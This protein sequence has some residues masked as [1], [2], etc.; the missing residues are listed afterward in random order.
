MAKTELKHNPS[1]SIKKKWAPCWVF[2]KFY[3]LFA[4]AGRAWVIYCL[5]KKQGFGDYRIS[6]I[7]GQEVGLPVKRRQG[8]ILVDKSIFLLEGEKSLGILKV[9]AQSRCSYRCQFT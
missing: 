9:G 4:V 6:F 2:F 3:F 1:Q 5:G 8:K 7:R